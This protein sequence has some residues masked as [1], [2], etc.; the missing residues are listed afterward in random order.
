[1]GGFTEIY[2]SRIVV[3]FDGSYEEFRHVINHELTH[4]FQYDILYGKNTASTIISQVT[5]DIPL[6]FI[7]EWLNTNRGGLI[8]KR[9]FS[10]AI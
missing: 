1:M 5:T 7:E 10:C 6:W 2:K 3:P 9:I 8:R 4:A